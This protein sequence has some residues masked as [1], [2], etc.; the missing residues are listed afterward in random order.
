MSEH[1]ILDGKTAKS[2]DL[3]EWAQWLETADRHVAKTTVNDEVNV[4]TVFIGL[5]Y[6][7]GSGPPLLF[8][9]MIFGGEHDQYQERFET[10]EQAEDGHKV[11]VALA[12][13]DED[14][15]ELNP[16]GKDG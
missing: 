10:W 2:V 9:T 16:A 11:A 8:E 15:Q 12:T 14:K 3:I 5:D 13:V 4:S 7:F 1:Y 6:S